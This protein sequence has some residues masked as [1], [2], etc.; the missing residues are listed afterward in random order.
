M[1]KHFPCKADRVVSRGLYLCILFL[2][3]ASYFLFLERYRFAH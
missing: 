3:L 1:S 2:L